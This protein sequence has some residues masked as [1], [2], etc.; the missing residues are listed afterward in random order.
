MKT[1][2]LVL[3]ACLALP[4][5]AQP[6]VPPVRTTSGGTPQAVPD[7]Q[8]HAHHKRQLILELLRVTNA[9]AQA[10]DT[11]KTTTDM[12][13]PEARDVLRDSLD[14]DEMVAQVV[15]V[16]EKYLSVAEIEGLLAFYRSPLGQRILAVQPKIMKD[17]IIV[18]RVYVEERITQMLKA[19]RQ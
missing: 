2:C 9:R 14:V 18:M 17:S 3:V 5:F 1:H 8:R 19:E 4:A 15:P 10:A 12:M 11:L 16:Y 7:V 13:P 6:V